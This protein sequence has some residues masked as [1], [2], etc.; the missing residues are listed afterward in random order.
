MTFSLDDCAPYDA[1]RFALPLPAGEG[2]AH[3]HFRRSYSAANVVCERG[4]TAI[5]AALYPRERE[6]GQYRDAGQFLK[7]TERIPADVRWDGASRPD[8]ARTV[9]YT[10]G[11]CDRYYAL[12]ETP[13]ALLELDITQ[14]PGSPAPPFAAM[15]AAATV[16]P[17]PRL[18]PPAWETFALPRFRVALPAEW[19]RHDEHNRPLIGDCVAQATG[20]AV[21]RDDPLYASRQMSRPRYRIEELAPGK[22]LKQYLVGLKTERHRSSIDGATYAPLGEDGVRTRGARGTRLRY[23]GYSPRGGRGPLEWYHELLLLEVG[24]ASLLITA[25][26]DWIERRDYAPVFAHITQSLAPPR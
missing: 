12:R 24:A 10:D 9:R 26:C 23:Q 17:A 21:S 15:I 1:L 19:P 25:Y 6:G 3:R 13:A 7:A 22:N 18:A 2:W 16:A 8:A 14:P 4:G 5:T 20:V 11:T